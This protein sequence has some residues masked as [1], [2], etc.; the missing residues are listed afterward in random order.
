MSD[1]LTHRGRVAAFSRSR[2]AD[3]PDLIEARQSLKAEGLAQHIERTVAEWPA[4]TPS[5]LDRLAI[6]LRGGESA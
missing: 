2:A 3:D 5:Q 6:L 1:I 4:L